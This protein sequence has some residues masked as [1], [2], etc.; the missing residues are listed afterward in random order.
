MSEEELLGGGGETERSFQNAASVP[1]LD[2]SGGYW[3]M[4][5]LKFTKLHT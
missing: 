1:H 2:Q 5:M 4:H 3:V